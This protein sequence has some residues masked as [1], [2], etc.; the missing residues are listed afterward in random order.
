MGVYRQATQ[1]P[2]QDCEGYGEGEGGDEGQEE[3][4]GWLLGVCSLL[5]KGKVIGC[6][7][8]STSCSCI[9]WRIRNTRSFSSRLAMVALIFGC[10]EASLFCLGVYLSIESILGRACDCPS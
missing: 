4:G 3:V 5:S 6:L 10:Y 1:E 8:V 2:S 7:C 9:E